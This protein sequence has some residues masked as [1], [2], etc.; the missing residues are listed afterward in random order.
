MMIKHN[1]SIPNTRNMI[2][3]QMVN[4]GLSS[5]VVCER[6]SKADHVV[7]FSGG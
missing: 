3:G 6:V 2:I 1:H 5:V 7:S 4:G